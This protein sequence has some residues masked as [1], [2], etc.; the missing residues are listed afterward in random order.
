MWLDRADIKCLCMKGQ[1][2]QQQRE[3]KAATSN[4]V[5]T[6]KSDAVTKNTTHCAVDGVDLQYNGSKG[7]HAL[8]STTTYQNKQEIVCARRILLPAHAQQREPEG[9]KEKREKGLG[10]KEH[11][12]C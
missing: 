5:E 12:K 10:N 2:E 4:K 3:L 7:H 1:C 8:V 6:T 11:K 9:E